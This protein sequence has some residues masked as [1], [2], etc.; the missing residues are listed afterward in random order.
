MKLGV[1][2]IFACIISILLLGGCGGGSGDSEDDQEQSQNNNNSSLSGYLFPEES[3]RGNGSFII[4]ASTGKGIPISNTTWSQQADIFP[5]GDFFQTPV[6][7]DHNYFLVS[8]RGCIYYSLAV[9]ISCI[10]VQDFNGNY[11]S[12]FNLFYDV[13]AVRMSPDKA[14]VALF[15]NTNPGSTNGEYLEIYN[16]NGDLIS[17]LLLEERAFQWH[18]TEGRIVYPVNNRQLQFTEPYST[19][20]SV[21]Y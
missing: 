21:V 6:D 7:Y 19:D 12:N 13:Y 8:S 16:L 20:A 15:R 2:C 9:D 10:A 11:V 5:S 18:P 4:D 14:H 1:K 17:D 3:N